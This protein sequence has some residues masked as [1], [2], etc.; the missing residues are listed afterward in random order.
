MVVNDFAYDGALPLEQATTDG[1]MKPAA[2][3]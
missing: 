3:Y 2:C 1:L